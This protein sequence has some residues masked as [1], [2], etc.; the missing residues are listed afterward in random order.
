MLIL[1]LVPP[2]VSTWVDKFVRR[3]LTDLLDS[4]HPPKE[5]VRDVSTHIIFL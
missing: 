3:V 2:H 1:I 5:G 4:D